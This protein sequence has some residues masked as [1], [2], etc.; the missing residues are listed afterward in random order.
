MVFFLISSSE[1]S[2]LYLLHFFDER[3]IEFLCVPMMP[4]LN[5]PGF[6]PKKFCE[7][8]SFVIIFNDRMCYALVFLLFCALKIFFGWQQGRD[9]MDY[10]NQAKQLF[11]KLS[12]DPQPP[13]RCSLE[14][15][16]YIFQWVFLL[17]TPYV[18]F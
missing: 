1:P 7:I 18:W 5:C 2:G 3:R 14:T 13:A 12:Q 6:S 4:N 10:Q 8:L 11:R 9:L 16:P 15:G 17:S